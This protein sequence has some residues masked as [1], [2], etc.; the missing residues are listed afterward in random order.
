MTRPNFHDAD[1]IGRALPMF[2]AA[3]RRYTEGYE[4]GRA[5][6]ASARNEKR[7]LQWRQIDAALTSLTN[8]QFEYERGDDE[9]G[10]M[11]VEDCRRALGVVA[12]S[13]SEGKDAEGYARLFGDIMR[14]PKRGDQ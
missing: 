14:E 11:H 12:L 9:A 6:E 4:D 2:S 5:A 8:A 7:V 3:R 10:R 1:Q 13:L